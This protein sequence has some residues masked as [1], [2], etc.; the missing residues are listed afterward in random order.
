MPA[1]VEVFVE[2]G[3]AT[4]DFTDRE[5]RAEGFAKLLEKTPPGLIQTVTRSGPRRQYRVPEG[6]AREAGL[7]DEG[8]DDAEAEAQ[9]SQAV[10]WKVTITGTGGT[11]MLAVDG[12]P[13]TALTPASTTAE[14]E[15]ALNAVSQDVGLDVAGTSTAYDVTT[16][17]PAELTV[18]AGAL[19][20]GTATVET[21][22]GAGPTD[23]YDTGF[24]D[25]LQ[26]ADPFA[27]ADQSWH[28]P[29]PNVSDNA[30]GSGVGTVT[31]PLRPNKAVDADV[32]AVP[33]GA[34]ELHADLQQRV[35]DATDAITNP[36]PEI[37]ARSEEPDETWKVDELR[38][39]AKANEINLEGATRK[40]DIL[41]KIRSS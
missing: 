31:G 24:A 37:P 13:T 22:S 36:P 39:H 15:T 21:T 25:A 32:T 10:A 40:D 41:D 19:T 11:Y 2:D 1:G 17:T 16:D 14:I 34:A 20:G 8:G 6:N 30:Y 26:A 27:E 9:S 33:D 3:F 23:R 38:E 12:A 29:V 5:K 35:H 28:Q 18:D 4:I 7:L